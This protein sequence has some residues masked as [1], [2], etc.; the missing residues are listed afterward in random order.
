M[1]AG[2]DFHRPTSGSEVDALLREHGDGARL[3]AGGTDLLVQM[4]NGRL[5]PSH[6]IDLGAVPGISS[7]EEE[8]NTIVIG[9]RAPVVDVGD[10]PTIR[11]DFEDLAEGCAKVGSIQIQNRATVGGNICNASPAADT[12]PALVA[13]RAEVVS[14][15]A[16]ESRAVRL[17]DFLV[18][19]GQTAL[20]PGEWVSAIRIPRPV[21]RNG[22]AY[23]KLGRTRGVDIAL[24]GAACHMTDLGV[25]IAFASIAATPIAVDVPGDPADA[26]P[27]AAA[28]EIEDRLR[29]IDDVRASS[30]Y[31]RAMA[32]VLAARAW[33]IAFERMHPQGVSG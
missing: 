14:T 10:H 26:L 17:E 32:L 23:V 27:A 30:D 5:R 28:E 29:P 16:G 11:A 4:R 20:R 21:E 33:R 19:P 7:V 2:F 18:A 15:L 22:G 3:L 13:H 6:V 8:P 31:R 12:V 1:L 25:R 24:V 9:A